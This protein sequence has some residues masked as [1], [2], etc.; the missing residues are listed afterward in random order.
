MQEFLKSLGYHCKCVSLAK[1]RCSASK[2]IFNFLVT[3]IP[4]TA[5]NYDF[6]WGSEASLVIPTCEGRE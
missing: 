4:I 6:W 2:T 5:K 1:V 3:I